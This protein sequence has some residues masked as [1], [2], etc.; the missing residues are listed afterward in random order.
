MCYVLRKQA[1]LGLNI[2]LILALSLNPI[3]S[4][5]AEDL[6][7]L[8]QPDVEP[9]HIDQFYYFYPTWFPE[10]AVHVWGF[11]E[12]GEQSTPHYLDHNDE[13]RVYLVWSPQYESYFKVG[14]KEYYSG[15]EYDMQLP[16]YGS[17][18]Y[19][20]LPENAD[21]G[22]YWIVLNNTYTYSRD[23]TYDGWYI[24]VS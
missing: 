8:P 21:D 11:G 18:V 7:K 6:P 9:D 23:C 22:F 24:V 5:I 16:I 10:D 13:V 20:E 14:L 2:L 12:E 3:A 17:Y 1:L 15:E 19:L 4:V